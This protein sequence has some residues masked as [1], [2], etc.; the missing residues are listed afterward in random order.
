MNLDLNSLDFIGTIGANTNI[1]NPDLRLPH[2]YEVT[3]LD[4][5]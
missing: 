3:G 5:T 2:T 4:R 1:V